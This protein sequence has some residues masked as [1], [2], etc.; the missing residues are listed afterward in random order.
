MDKIKHKINPDPRLMEALAE[1][2]AGAGHEINNPLATITSRVQMLLARESDVGKRAQLESIGAQAMR[3]RDMIT[4][5]MLFARPPE[6]MFSMID[7]NEL[8]GIVLEQQQ[9]Y[10]TAKQI[11]LALEAGGGPSIKAD[12][13]QFQ[14]VFN[15]LI[16]NS[17]EASSSGQEVLVKAEYL[18]KEQL[19]QITVEDAGMGF[20]EEQAEH[21]FNPYYSGR[22]AGRGHGF[23]LSKCWAIMRLHGGE[24]TIDCSTKTRVITTWKV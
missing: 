2:A 22:Q 10:A 6:P 15:E 20:T 17:I 18:P 11:Q 12:V 19:W 14:V 16:R 5:I 3:I 24:I 4:D 8:L 1:F 21:A 23:G 9:E 13:D 7:P